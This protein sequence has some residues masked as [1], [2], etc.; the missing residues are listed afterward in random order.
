MSSPLSVVVGATGDVGY[1]IV[2]ALLSS[3]HTV[4]AVSRSLSRLQSLYP[5]RPSH[6]HFVEGSVSDDSSA[7]NLWKSILSVSQGRTINNVITSVNAPRTPLRLTS[8]TSQTFSEL[9][10]G[11][12]VSHFVAARTFIPELQ[13]SSNG[14]PQKGVY[15]AIGGGAAD[16][17]W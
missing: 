2:K 7:S 10:Q 14:Q 1:G 13:K 11:N 6:L 15:L 9:L 17:V 5:S 3:S 16:F 4:I 12:L 8:M